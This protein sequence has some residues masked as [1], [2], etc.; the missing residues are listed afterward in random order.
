MKDKE[1]LIWKAVFSL[2][3]KNSLKELRIPAGTIHLS[4]TKNE[5]YITLVA[6]SIKKV[7]GLDKINFGIFC[8]I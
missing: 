4:I 2:S 6:K 7:P 3:S 1:T 8:M 5:V